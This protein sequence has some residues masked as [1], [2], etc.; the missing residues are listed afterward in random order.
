MTATRS[1]RV[2]LIGY[3]LGGSTF[4][5]PLISATP[6]LELAAIATS[7][8]G[9]VQAAA[10]RHPQAR[11]VPA[12]GSAVHDG[13]GARPRR[14]LD[15]APHPRAAGESGAGRRLPRRDRQA[16]RGQRGRGA[17]AGRARGAL[18][19]AGDPLPEPA[20]GRR[21]PDA[22]AAAARRRARR[23]CTASSRATSAGVRRRNR[24]GPPRAPDARGEGLLLDLMVH[25]VDQ[26]LLLFGP[27]RDV[28]AEFDR[29][30]PQVHVVRRRVPRHHP[31]QRRP[32]APVHQRHGRHRRA[33]PERPRQRRRVREAR[34]GPAGGR[35]ARR[36]DAGRRR[37][38]A[39][40]RDELGPARRRRRDPHRRERGRRLPALLRRR[41]A[42]AGDG[43]AAAR[44]R[45]RG[46]GDDGRARS[47][48]RLGPRAP[49]R[50]AARPPAC[51]AADSRGRA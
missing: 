13:A 27:A 45:R 40:G 8:A 6:G 12:A 37:L 43:R 18:R 30:H 42:R 36:R 23:P 24:A 32:L 22:A 46:G 7:D 21:H 9:R 1:L 15:A 28:Y 16:V 47:R 44:H 35:A 19:P 29:R 25:L 2:G 11:I 34:H 3:G 26:A 17:R 48:A 49:R 10:A 38:G 39:R 33:A 5:A 31:R 41:A 4:H 50:R 14:R 51:G 20:L